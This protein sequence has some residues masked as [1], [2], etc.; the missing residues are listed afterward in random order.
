MAQP[1]TNGSR[2]SFH[3]GQQIELKQLDV[4]KMPAK[5]IFVDFEW[6]KGV[7]RV[8]AWLSN[9]SMPDNWICVVSGDVW[10]QCSSLLIAE[11]ACA[12]RICYDKWVR[13]MHECSMSCRLSCHIVHHFSLW[14]HNFF[15]ER[16]NN[17][18]TPFSLSLYWQKRW[19]RMNLRC[20]AIVAIPFTGRIGRTSAIIANRRL[21]HYYYYHLIRMREN[22]TAM[23]KQPTVWQAVHSFSIFCEL[24]GAFVSFPITSI[25]EWF[26]FL[27]SAFFFFSYEMGNSDEHNPNTTFKSRFGCEKFTECVLLVDTEQLRYGPRIYSSFRHRK[28]H[29]ISH[30]TATAATHNAWAMLFTFYTQRRIGFIADIKL[31]CATAKTQVC[32]CTNGVHLSKRWPVAVEILFVCHMGKLYIALV[33]LSVCR[34]ICS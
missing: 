5:S 18:H 19:K 23:K 28:S 20:V 16:I 33:C 8:S 9:P 31:M 15:G 11:C 25:L 2:D 34:C 29:Q 14:R 21:I 6:R 1:N 7:W 17:I 22:I 10:Q 32:H 13:T 12:S 24:V 26:S 4:V 3:C 27:H 30:S